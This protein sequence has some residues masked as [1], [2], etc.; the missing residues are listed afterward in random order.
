MKPL[1]ERLFPARR[2]LRL[3]PPQLRTLEAEAHRTAT[4]LELFYDLAF[5][6][7]VAVLGERL[8]AAH[9][10]AGVFSYLGYFF[11]VWWLWAS[12][13]FY[14]DRYDTDDL[15]YRLLATT[16]LVAV[17]IIAAS[18]AP[19]VSASATAFAV[20][21][22]IAR[23]AL[24]VMYWR[25]RRHVVETRALVSGYLIGFGLGAALWTISIFAPDNTRYTLWAVAIAIDL[26]T[27]WLMRGEQ[28][29]AP[30][31]TSHLPERFGLFTILI[32][33]ESIAATVIGLSGHEWSSASIFAGIMALVIATAIW[34]LYFDN[35]EGL[36]VRRTAGVA[37]T[38]RPTV[39]IYSH[40]GLAAGLGIMS[41]GLEHAIVA[42][43]GAYDRFETWVLVGG[44]ALA[45]M[46][47]ALTH[48]ASGDEA[49]WAIH[50]RVAGARALSALGILALG[51]FG[52]TSSGL[53]LGTAVI[54]V[55]TAAIGIT[56]DV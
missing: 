11:L 43:G 30:L 35:V 29:R 19:G 46:S 2:R 48:L 14:A 56:R 36:V 18:L 6:V 50:N 26:A 17:A 27:P 54:L 12:H 41:I 16:Q 49:T 52:M 13:T 1:P 25:A 9:D 39:W 15:V 44:T 40:A 24:L 7:A 47:L 34:W 20:G 3:R 4:W 45:T 10:L 31:D 5:V 33:G 32:L 21:Y 37:R 22:T 55:G 53:A 28:A 51:L 23:L 38:W 42:A 8:G